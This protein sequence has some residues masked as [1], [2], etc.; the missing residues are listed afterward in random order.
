MGRTTEL[1]ERTLQPAL[2]CA[3]LWFRLEI[4]R[5]SMRSARSRC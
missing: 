5:D 1:I 3:V 2:G 4:Y